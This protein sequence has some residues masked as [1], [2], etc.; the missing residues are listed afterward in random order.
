M[1]H[2]YYFLYYWDQPYIFRDSANPGFHEA[3]GDTL[4]LSVSTPQH[5]V[6]IG[7][8][9][10]Y[11]K[12]KGELIIRSNKIRRKYTGTSPQRP[13]WGQESRLC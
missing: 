6:K 7:L 3:V 1:G 10:N 5:L 13:P 4:S 9:D 11:V 12:D 2:I 8:L